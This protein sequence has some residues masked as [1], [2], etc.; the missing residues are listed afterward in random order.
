MSPAGVL[1]PRAAVAGVGH[2]FP[3]S[4]ALRRTAAGVSGRQVRPWLLSAGYVFIYEL[5]VQSGY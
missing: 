4:A 3:G 2:R 5:H 1:H